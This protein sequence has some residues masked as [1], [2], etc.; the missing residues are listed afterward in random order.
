M[1]NQLAI[2][3]SRTF[4]IDTSEEVGATLYISD[5]RVSSAADDYYQ[6]SIE[7]CKKFAW[8]YFQVPKNAWKPV[9]I[10][11]WPFATNTVDTSRK[12]PLTYIEYRLIY[13]LKKRLVSFAISRSPIFNITI[14]KPILTKLWIDSTHMLESNYPNKKFTSEDNNKRVSEFLSWLDESKN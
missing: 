7:E 11:Y 9:D 1:K 14:E 13:E 6:N 10:N 4:L 12:Q 5:H 8:T 2:T 3:N